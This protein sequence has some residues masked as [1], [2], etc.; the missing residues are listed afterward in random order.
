MLLKAVESV[1]F[2]PEKGLW[3]IKGEEATALE[4][5]KKISIIEIP[6]AVFAQILL[7][8]SKMAEKDVEKMKKEGKEKI[9]ET[10]REL[11]KDE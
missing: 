3:R 1:S 4:G 2:S 8:I 9:L 11:K 6:E 10:K 7:K 5:V